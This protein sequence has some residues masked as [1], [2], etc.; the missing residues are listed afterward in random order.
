VVTV[1]GGPTA[2]DCVV[3]GDVMLGAGTAVVVDVALDVEIVDV[4][5]AAAGRSAREQSALA[6]AT[7]RAIRRERR[8]TP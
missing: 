7:P 8:F 6:S 3:T 5:T 4:A 1:S 2:G